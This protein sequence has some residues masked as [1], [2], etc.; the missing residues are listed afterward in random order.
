MYKPIRQDKALTTFWVVFIVAGM[1]VVGTWT[2]ALS[3]LLKRTHQQEE[4]GVE[5]ILCTQSE[6]CITKEVDKPV[7]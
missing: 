7:K 3:M 2:L 4:H 1:F 6:K 5:L